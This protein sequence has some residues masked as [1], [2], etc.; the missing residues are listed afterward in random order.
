MKKILIVNNNLHIGG[1]QHALV[2]LL[3]EIAV[4]PDLD[5]TV[6]LFSRRGAL[7]EQLPENVH[8]ISPAVPFRCW[9]LVRG[10]KSTFFDKML[11]AFFAVLTRLIGRSCALKFAYPFQKKLR[12]YD[13]AVSYLHCG[14]PKMFYGGCNEFVMQCV[15]ARK[16]ITF[17]HCDYEKIGADCPANTS[18]YDRFDVIA[19]CSKGCRNSFLR[20]KPQFAAKTVVVQN[21]HDFARLATIPN[22][23]NRTEHSPLRFITVARLGKEKGVVRAIRAI[24]D[25]GELAKKMHYD[26]FGNGS[27]FSD[28]QALISLLGLE[29][30]VTLHGEQ[31]EPY[32]SMC[33]SDVLLIPSVSEAAPLVIGEA[34]ALGVPILTTETSSAREMVEQ[35]GY[36]WVCDNSEAGLQQGIK[37]L[38]RNP[39][40]IVER[41]L[42]LRSLTFNNDVAVQQ[43]LDLLS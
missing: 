42:F 28:A 23:D 17:M 33:F 30:I 11:R 4:E 36:G 37:R 13:V 15:E 38:I 10:D 43:F 40:V 2:N 3:H 21:C 24:S 27:E 19:A 18:L 14:G 20:V 5:I 8:V 39:D 9:G 1:V 35:T 29:S 6:L 31:M 7:M 22:L 41:A 25:L 12:G 16:K 26:V 32:E 34:A